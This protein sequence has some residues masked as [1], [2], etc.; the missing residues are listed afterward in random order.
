MSTQ[1]ERDDTIREPDEANNQP[2]GFKSIFNRMVAEREAKFDAVVEE[3]QQHEADISAAVE[4]K[5]APEIYPTI[6]I[7]LEMLKKTFGV[8]TEL[9]KQTNATEASCFDGKRW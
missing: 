5:H 3:I 7:D 9:R 8:I 2:Y 6:A 4:A 1:G